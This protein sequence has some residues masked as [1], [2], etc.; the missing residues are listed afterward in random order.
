MILIQAIIEDF[1]TDHLVDSFSLTVTLLIFLVMFGIL[2]YESEKE[3]RET[4]KNA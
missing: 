2:L 3:E 1:G 4:D